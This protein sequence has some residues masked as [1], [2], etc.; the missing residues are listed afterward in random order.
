[1][2]WFHETDKVITIEVVLINGN[3]KQNHCYLLVSPQS[4][5]LSLF[6]TDR[7]SKT[8]LYKYS[9]RSTLNAKCGTK[10]IK[11]K[12]VIHCSLLFVLPVCVHT[13]VF[14]YDFY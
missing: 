8:K 13:H 7:Q 1:M 4:L 11:M 9:I 12:Y 10:W 3:Y 2:G 14:M 6:L 5:I